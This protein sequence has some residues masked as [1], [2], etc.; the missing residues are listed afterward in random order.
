L[1][2]GGTG[3]CFTTNRAFRLAATFKQGDSKMKFQ[4][5]QSGNPNGRSPGAGQAKLLAKG[6][7]AEAVSV[8]A[9][10]STDKAAPAGARVEAAQSLLSVAGL[11]VSTQNH[12]A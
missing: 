9:S 10:I 5:G 3:H 4:P 12:A 7:A 2:S 11:T 1:F 6:Y 8:L